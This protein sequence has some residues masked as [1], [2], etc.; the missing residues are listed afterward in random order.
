M[1]GSKP[2]DAGGATSKKPAKDADAHDKPANAW[3][4]NFSNVTALTTVAKM[5]SHPNYQA[6]KSGNRDAAAKMVIDLMGG[7]E[8]QRKIKE[9]GDKYPDAIVV[10]V[11]AEEKDGRNAIPKGLSHYIAKVAGLEITDDIVQTEK[12]G[13]TGS[14]AMHRLAFRPKFDGEV[15]PGNIFLWTMLLPAAALSENFAITSKARAARWY[16]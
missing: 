11:H 7:K 16:T 8:Q 10:G 2:K 9:L 12:V 14:D 4:K 5:K 15:K 1:N 6:A 13:R 3:P